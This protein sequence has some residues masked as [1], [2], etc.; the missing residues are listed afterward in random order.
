[1]RGDGCRGDAEFCGD[2]VDRVLGDVEVYPT[3]GGEAEADVALVDPCL[4][5]NTLLHSARSMSK[6]D[7]ITSHSALPPALRRVHAT[8]GGE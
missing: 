8:R 5:E 7:A 1:L 6:I 4:G 2:R 3:V